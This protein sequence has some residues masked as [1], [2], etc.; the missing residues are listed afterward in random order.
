MTAKNSMIRVLVADDHP[1]V[2][3]GLCELLGAQADM[4][5]AAR[6]ENGLEAVEK[7]RTANPD[8]VVVDL[9]MPGLGG[10]EVAR[11]IKR[12]MPQIGIVVLS[13]HDK[14]AYVLQALH[15]GATAYVLKGA[16]SAEILRAVHAARRGEYYLCSRISKGVIESFLKSRRGEPQVEPYDLLS[17]REQQV[18][19]LLVEG[20]SAN[21][22][23]DMLCVSPKTVEKHRA[24]TMKKLNCTD[25]LSL[26]KYAVKVGILDPETWK[27]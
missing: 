10:V 6:A 27:G 15:A 13:M 24:N 26:V 17:E 9:S 22:I 4:E 12:E 3:M 19:R 7:A 2:L 8:V 1:I 21:R 11:L 25:L 20:H 14:E 5:V 16:A 23:A 18:F